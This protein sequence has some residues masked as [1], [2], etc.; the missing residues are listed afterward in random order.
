MNRSSLKWCSFAAIAVT[1]LSLLPQL[2]LWYARGSQWNGAY[3]T[4]DGD[5]FLYSAYINALLDGRSRRNDPFAGRDDNPNAPLQESGYSINVVPAFVIYSLAKLF[6]VSS[7]TAF[8]V[9]IGLAGLLASVA[10]FYLILSVTHDERVAAAGTL[11]VLCLGGAA[12]GQG[13]LGILFSSDVTNLGLIFLRRYQPS[14]SFALFFVFATLIWRALVA[15]NNS[16]AWLYAVLGGAVL[17]ALV[18]CYFYL[19]TAAAAWLAGCGLLWFCFRP[20]ARAR[21]IQVL[22]I[23]M[24]MALFALGPYVYL[25]SQRS[26]SLDQSQLLI[27]THRLDLLRIPEIIGALVLIVLVVAGRRG[28]LKFSGVSNI[29]TASFALLPFI[30]FNQQVVTGRSLQPF[31]FENFIANY[32]VLVG[33]VL[34]IATLTR[35]SPNFWRLAFVV[36]FVWGALEVV[37]PARARYAANVVSDE[38][39]PAMKRL[40]ELSA[41]DGT[42]SGLRSVGKTPAVVFSP[43]TDVMRVVPTWTAQGILLGVGSL[44]FGGSRNELKVYSYLYYSGVNGERLR[45]LLNDRSADTFMNYYARSAIFGLPRVSPNLTFNFKPIQ[46]AEIEDQVRN[47]ETYVASFN[48]EAALKH[49]LGYLVIRRDAAFDFSLIDR[50]YQRAAAEHYGPYDLYRLSLLN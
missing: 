49:P 4:V 17:C 14:A 11:F 34:L 7:S 9:L 27:S 41:T 50:W 46:N 25:L 29:F 18:F 24:V 8:I 15:G 47:Y 5:E 26:T 32:A 1:F 30:L 31:H 16:R 38:M 21:T 44:D 19:W 6:S 3:A 10:I 40:K 2:H 28:K 20:E 43:H 45:E 42:L 23:V 35:V 39:I 48:R 13:L 37:L 33:V 36:C 12:A 22:A